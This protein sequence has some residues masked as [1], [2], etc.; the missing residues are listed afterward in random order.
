[1]KRF[2]LTLS[3]LALTS[4]AVMNAQV[5]IGKDVAPNPNAVL[6]LVTPGNNMGF[7]P[8]RVQLL[9]PHNPAPLAAHVEGMIVYNTVVLQDSLMAGL[10]V[11]NG[12]QWTLLRQTPY[13]I[14]NWFYMPS[15][16]IK[17][18]TSG[19]FQIDLWQ[20]FQRQF[21]SLV[22]GNNIVASDQT[23]PKPLPVIRAANEFYY[24]VTG[25]D[26]TVFKN[27][28]LSPTGILGYEITPA[29]RV[30]VSDSTFMNIVLVAK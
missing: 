10:Y 26:N 25:Y 19:A 4:S 14:P 17:T 3:M 13:L 16:P 8:P 24:Y 20:E 11:N 15:I 21:D 1:M 30:N 29:S 6:E 2:I 5:T 22:A 27:L 23:A 28:T 18:S 9:T 7:L 12:T